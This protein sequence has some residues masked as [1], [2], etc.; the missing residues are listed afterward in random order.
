MI[1]VSSV[2]LGGPTRGRGRLEGV[3]EDPMAHE[4]TGSRSTGGVFLFD[5]FR[6]NLIIDRYDVGLRV[7]RN[8][9]R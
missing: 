1:F 2:K 7:L 8:D 5:D 9:R 3:I 6:D 4:A